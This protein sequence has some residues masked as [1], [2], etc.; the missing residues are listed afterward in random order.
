MDFI[1][2]HTIIPNR[3]QTHKEQTTRKYPVFCNDAGKVTSGRRTVSSLRSKISLHDTTLATL[4]T[5]GVQSPSSVIYES[6]SGFYFP[7]ALRP[8]YGSWLPL[9]GLHDH[10][11]SVE[12]LWT[13]DQPDAQTS[14]STPHNIHKRQTLMPT[15]GFEPAIPVSERQQ[16]Y[17]LDQC[18]STFVRP[19]LGK[20]FFHKTRDRSQQIYS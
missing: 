5:F 15:A 11:H 1:T 7:A 4:R 14:T 20:F 8:D 13:R 6:Q 9:T 19:R 12:L 16:M 18:F 3:I 2:R 17:A 10:S